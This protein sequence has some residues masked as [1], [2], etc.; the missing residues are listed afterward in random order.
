MAGQGVGVDLPSL[1]NSR[2]S[3]NME[4]ETEAS[5][6]D[7]V[8]KLQNGLVLQATNGVFEGGDQVYSRL[9]TELLGSPEAKGRLPDF[10]RR[11]RDL[12]QFWQFIK[13][14]YPTYVE[15]RRYIWD[16]FHALIEHLETQNASPGNGSIT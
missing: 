16:A 7:K 1:S 13:Y 14:A 6:L 3:L 10:V 15:R 4:D 5:L 2:P 12:S 8:I 11:N 9:R